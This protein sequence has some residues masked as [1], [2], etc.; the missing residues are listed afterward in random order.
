M[1]GIRE[2]I[3]ARQH[4]AGLTVADVVLAVQPDGTESLVW[5]TEVLAAIVQVGSP[6]ECLVAKIPVASLAEAERLAHR[7]W[8]ACDD[9]DGRA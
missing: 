8:T 6:Q 3:L 2:T 4:A 1:T 9:A 7:Y 5:G